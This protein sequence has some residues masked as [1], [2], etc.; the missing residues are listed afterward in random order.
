MLD[1]IISNLILSDE[2]ERLSNF[3][4]KNSA[5]GGGGGGGASN[6]SRKS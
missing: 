1:D 2:A 6:P 3:T 4:A 5:G